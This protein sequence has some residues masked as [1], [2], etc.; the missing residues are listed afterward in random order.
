M[1]T[2]VP[3]LSKPL[4]SGIDKDTVIAGSTVVVFVSLCK[5]YN[6]FL[7]HPKE[8][9]S[10]LAIAKLALLGIMACVVT[11]AC[12]TALFEQSID[13][14]S[15]VKGT[16]G[17]MSKQDEATMTSSPTLTSTIPKLTRIVR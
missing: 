4:L 9:F 12:I 7:S 6:I 15:T 5:L 1:M 17:I 2:S 11:R 16:F 10:D 13:V 3:Q 8:Y 14:S